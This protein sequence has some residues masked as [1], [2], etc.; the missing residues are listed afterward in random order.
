MTYWRKLLVGSHQSIM[1][2][3]EKWDRAGS[4]MLQRLGQALMV[5]PEDLISRCSVENAGLEEGQERQA[6]TDFEEERAERRRQVNRIKR[7]GHYGNAPGTVLLRGL[8]DRRV[9]AGLTQRE[10]AKVIRTN[11]TTIALLEKGTYRGAYMSTI[12]KL[13]RALELSLANLICRD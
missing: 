11:Q 10:L 7:R 1:A 3:L 9:A 8:K 13:C 12:K 2:D 6:E 4:D 5:A